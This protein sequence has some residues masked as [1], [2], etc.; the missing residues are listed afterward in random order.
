MRTIPTRS[1]NAA[2]TFAL[3]LLAHAALVQAPAAQDA[4]RSSRAERLEWPRTFSGQPD[5]LFTREE[6]KAEARVRAARENEAL[7]LSPS[8]Q[9]LLEDD[10]ALDPLG[11][12]APKVEVVTDASGTIVSDTTATGSRGMSLMDR[13]MAE[14]LDLPTVSS[15]VAPNLSEFN[16]QLNVA[17]NNAVA[18]WQPA[19]GG[20]NIDSVLN[21]VSLQAIVTS[22]VKYAVINQQRYAEGE[23]F[24]I[25]V[26]VSVP[27][28]VITAA[29]DTIMP[30]PGTLT[31]ALE[32]SYAA[33][34]KKAWDDFV[35]K[36]NQ[37][38]DLG[39]QSLVLPVRI[40]G[41]T[42]RQ[43]L[44]DVNGQPYALQ[45]RYAY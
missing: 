1:T 10:S 5:F 17:I 6:A 40:T 39:R 15:T 41:I 34:Y 37:N 31:A 7:P 14:T 2:L 29:M 12:N 43:V 19:P 11:L 42:A 25:N 28:A 32:E 33:A 21:S 35:F 45:I 44:L 27:D 13:L 3:A 22:P 30:A 4:A 26:P 36:R 24:R 8:L 18:G 9:Q 38:P 16:A 23:V 20:Y